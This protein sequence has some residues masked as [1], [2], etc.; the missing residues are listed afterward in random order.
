MRLSTTTT[1][2]SLSDPAVPG[3]SLFRAMELC[4]NAGFRHLDLNFGTQGQPGFPLAADGW[5]EWADKAR[6][7]AEMNGQT[8]YQ[9]HA[10]HYR[11][12]ESTSRKIDRPWY[13]ERFRRSILAAQRLGVRWLVMHPSDFDADERYDF[14]KARRYNLEYWRPFIDLAAR[15][16]VGFAFENMFMS[17]RHPRYCSD[18]DELIDLTD[19]FHDPMVGVCWDTGHASVAGQD[20]PAAIRKLGP[21]L[22]ATHIHDNHGRPGGDEHLTPYYGTL[23]WPGILEALHDIGYENN[24]SLELK[25]ATQPLP[26]ALCGEMLR[27][28][29][30]LGDNMIGQADACRKDK[31]AG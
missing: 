25:H 2:L 27:F 7:Q 13:E 15:C 26:P 8:F 16:G 17:G 30:S 20:Q 28:L 9:A 31:A 3:Q 1:I 23:D 22:K 11:T 14:D 29:H 5:M 12:S 19:A 18:V 21:R 10:F 6:E 4:G 24:F